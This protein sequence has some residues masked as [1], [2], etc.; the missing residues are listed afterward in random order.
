MKI[1]EEDK[2]IDI[3]IEEAIKLNTLGYVIECNDGKVFAIR[4]EKPEEKQEAKRSK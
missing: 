3:T 2:S 4:Q 1:N